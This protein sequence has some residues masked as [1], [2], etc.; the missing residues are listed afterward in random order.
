MLKNNME[1]LKINREKQEIKKLL[2]NILHAVTFAFWDPF[3]NYDSTSLRYLLRKGRITEYCRLVRSAPAGLIYCQESDKELIKAVEK[4]NEVCFH[5]CHAGLVDFAFPLT[6]KN[7]VIPII[8]GQIL[9]KP[10]TAEELEKIIGNLAKKIPTDQF[11]L[12]KAL[13]KVPIVSP[14]VLKSILAL[15]SSI[16]E[17]LSVNEVIKIISNISG[18]ISKKKYEKLYKTVDFLKEHYRE[19]LSINKIAQKINISPSYLTHLFKKHTGSSLT[20]YRENLRIESAKELLISSQ[21]TI[22]EVAFSLGWN[23][24]NY[25]SLIFKK[26]T[27]LSPLTYRKTH[28]KSRKL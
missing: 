2:E 25:F 27:G 5:H 8:G 11:L 24:S 14:Q 1:Y 13:K 20:S 18:I 9:F 10:Y 19:N 4:S 28:N 12:K 22:T 17:R 23:D 16:F 7:K 3:K 26:R 15:F 6:I 21:V